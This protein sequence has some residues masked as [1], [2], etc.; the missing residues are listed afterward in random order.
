MSTRGAVG[1][2]MAVIARRAELGRWLVDSQRHRLRWGDVIE[3]AA[4]DVVWLRAEHT[5]VGWLGPGRHELTGAASPAFLHPWIGNPNVQLFFVVN[6]PVPYRC[7]GTAFA[8]EQNLH[9]IADLEFSLDVSLRIES[10]DRLHARSKGMLDHGAFQ[11]VVENETRLVTKKAIEDT[12]WRLDAGELL[13]FG[14]PERLARV[15]RQVNEWWERY[16]IGATGFELSVRSGG[17]L[18]Q[19]I[20]S[21][22]IGEPAEV[23]YGKRV[24]VHEEDGTRREG[25]IADIEGPRVKLHWDDGSTSWVGALRCRRPS[26]APTLA[27]GTR[28]HAFAPDHTWRAATALRRVNGWWDVRFDAG[29]RAWLPPSFIRFL[30]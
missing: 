19:A 20:E 15:E 6:D 7:S 24:E 3:C 21:A 16:S 17:P 29:P 22:E 10:F 9:A 28:V 2:R 5:L 18:L 27:A 26:A 25:V 30:T 4:N 13:A 23:G 14:S 11:Q 1:D 8:Y 12:A